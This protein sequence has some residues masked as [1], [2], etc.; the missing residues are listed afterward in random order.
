M[1]FQVTRSFELNTDE[2]LELY[3]KSIRMSWM[4]N[5]VICIDELY[6]VKTGDNYIVCRNV[7]GHDEEVDD[8][9][10]LFLALCNILANT[11]PNSPYR[12]IAVFENGKK[13]EFLWGGY[14]SNDG[15][16]SVTD[17]V[18][19]KTDYLDN[20]G[21]FIVTDGNRVYQNYFNIYNQKFMVSSTSVFLVEDTCVKYWKNL[22]KPYN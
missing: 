15:W 7:N 11:Y 17:R 10:E 9:G 4:L 13:I 8:R 21:R 5:H 3:F 19:T 22:P 1:E 14:C 18:P 12:N 20:D 2:I 6:V 16:I